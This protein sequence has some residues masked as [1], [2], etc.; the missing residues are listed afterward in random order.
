MRVWDVRGGYGE[1]RLRRLIDVSQSA[2]YCTQGDCLKWFGMKSE[3]NCRA[4]LHSFTRLSNS[5]VGERG[6]QRR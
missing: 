4:M 2:Q 5:A 6:G 1:D 3:S